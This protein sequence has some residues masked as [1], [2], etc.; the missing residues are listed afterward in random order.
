MKH[1][2]AL[3][4]E[5]NEEG[6]V[7]AIL[8]RLEEQELPR[9]RDLKAKVDQGGVLD[10]LDI[11]FLDR[12]FTDIDEMRLLLERHPELAEMA[13]RMMAQCHAITTQDL[14]NE[15]KRAGV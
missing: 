15:K 7:T 12:V 11:A 10:E 8:E 3:E 14:V 9:A 5:T 4:T 2:T 13:G 6:V 1:E